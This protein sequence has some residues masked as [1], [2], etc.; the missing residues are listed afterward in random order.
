MKKTEEKKEK[1]KRLRTTVSLWPEIWDFAQKL[2][3][4]RGKGLEV[5]YE[6]YIKK[7]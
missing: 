4:T 2:G 1:K 3:G 7:K 5:M 6:Y